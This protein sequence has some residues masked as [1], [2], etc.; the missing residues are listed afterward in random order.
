[1]KNDNIHDH[2]EH[3]NVRVNICGLKRG[4]TLE[5]YGARSTCTGDD[6]WTTLKTSCGTHTYKRG[7][8]TAQYYE[9]RSVTEQ[10][11]Y[12]PVT[13]AARYKKFSLQFVS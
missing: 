13:T 1:M 6:I 3:K 12:A 4:F 9:T 2:L 10:G 11:M 5:R 7:E 8:F